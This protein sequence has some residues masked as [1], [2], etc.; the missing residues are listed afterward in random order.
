MSMIDLKRSHKKELM[1]SDKFLYKGHVSEP[2]RRLVST[3]A[4]YTLILVV[5]LDAHVAYYIGV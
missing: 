1:L 2:Y 3:T 5:G 4:L